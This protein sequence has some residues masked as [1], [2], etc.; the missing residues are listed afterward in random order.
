[1]SLTG[2]LNSAVSSLK[3]TQSSIQLL[4]SNV[5][6]ANDPNYTKKT[7][8]QQTLFNGP[9][10]VGGVGIA[11]Y[12]NAVSAALRKQYE[13]LTAKDG[14]TSTQ[15][16]LMSQ[17]Q[18]LLGSSTDSAALP[19]LLADFT[20]AWQ[21]FQA[22]PDS[23]TA[24]SQV[25]SLGDRFAQEINRLSTGIDQIDRD[26]R[27]DTDNSVKQFNDL[28]DQ[29]YTVNVNLKTT[30]DTDV[31]HGDLIDQR[32]ALV[33]QISQY[34]DVRTVERDNGSVAVFTTA[35][36][37]LVDGPPQKF[38]YNG[39]N[40]VS[41][42]SGQPID[43]LL[44]DGKL[45]ALLNF[46]A[47]SSGANQAPSSDP[48]TEVIRKLKSQIDMVVQAFTSVT[49]Q[50]ATFAAAYD[51]AGSSQRIQAAFSTTVQATAATA[52]SSTVTLSGSIQTGDVFS[53]SI[54]GKSYSY[55]ATATDTSLDQ[56]AQQLAGKINADTTLGVTAVNGSASLQ[57]LASN[58][59]VP[60]EVKTTVN[61]QVPELSG[62]FFT[63]NDRYSFSVN[64]SLLDGTQQLK[65]NAAS[66][67]VNALGSN[68]RN[69]I[70]AGLTVTNSS[71]KGMAAGLIGNASG[72]AKSL[73]DQAKFNSDALTMT[74]QR[75]QTNVGVNMD[76]EIANL[77]V[78]QN[79]YSASARLLTVIQSMFDTLQQAVSR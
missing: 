62:G 28:L 6:H 29:L 20:T 53:V 15:S 35:G 25:I 50:P 38:S 30:D 1:M 47:D 49:G 39:T 79:A 12:Q 10:Q 72:N 54:N 32:D 56:I 57:L 40:I 60:F 34:A 43:G 48:G 44:R 70:A 55:T 2:A 59:N 17:V 21:N 31:A 42:E 26:V 68:D 64:A 45:K 36:Q 58:N 27:T 41:L 19:S 8:A 65:R 51:N 18:D 14:T 63:G 61:D 78:L 75:Y 71:Y 23:A 16:D 7:L 69:F 76:E 11:A 66:D 74:Q 24:Q 73:S 22:S 67:M 46:R 37:T 33:R 3:V 52:Q 77:Q 4:S 9:D 5:A 13:Q